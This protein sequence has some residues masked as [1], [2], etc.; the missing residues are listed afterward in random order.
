MGDDHND[1]WKSN[2]V[3]P[4]E[5]SSKDEWRTEHGRPVGFG[6]GLFD[7]WI[8][9]IIILGVLGVIAKIL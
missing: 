5:Y 4:E 9:A 7:W 1:D 6:S 8:L 3:F 2:R